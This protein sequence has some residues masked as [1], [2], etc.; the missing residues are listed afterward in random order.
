LIS[1]E[2]R[3]DNNVA[4]LTLAANK[5]SSVGS[6][7]LEEAVKRFV[8]L[9]SGFSIACTRRGMAEELTL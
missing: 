8:L 4:K 6:T 1:Q 7:A 9:Q 5:A 3:E 2:G